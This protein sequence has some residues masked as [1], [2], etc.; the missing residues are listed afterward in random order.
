MSSGQV[1]RLPGT[2]T[3]KAQDNIN[4]KYSM[5]IGLVSKMS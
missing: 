5:K 4:E 2:T 1:P 3:K